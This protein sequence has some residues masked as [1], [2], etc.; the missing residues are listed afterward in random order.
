MMNISTR[1]YLKIFTQLLVE[2]AVRWNLKNMSE[3]LSYWK[4]TLCMDK[5]MMGS[6]INTLQEAIFMNPFIEKKILQYCR[7]YNIKKKVYGHNVN[8]SLS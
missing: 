2:C 5:V 4:L 3:S 1:V 8:V 7:Y 6:C